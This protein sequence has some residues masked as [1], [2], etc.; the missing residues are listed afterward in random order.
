MYGETCV[1]A[2]VT[3]SGKHTYIPLTTDSGNVIPLKADAMLNPVS[4]FPTW[5]MEH[6]FPSNSLQLY[7]T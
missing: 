1:K 7:V 5:N 6:L 4:Y 3:A 2:I